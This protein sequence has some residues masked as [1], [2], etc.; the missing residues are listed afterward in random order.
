MLYK[1]YIFSCNLSNK[2]IRRDTINILYWKIHYN[3]CYTKEY[4]NEFKKYV[5][6]YCKLKPDLIIVN[7]NDINQK[8][9]NMIFNDKNSIIFCLK[10]T[11]NGQKNIW[12]RKKEIFAHH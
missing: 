11:K 6:L 12:K 4:Y 3:I 1:K 8:E 9:K 2:D 7:S 5:E 10:T